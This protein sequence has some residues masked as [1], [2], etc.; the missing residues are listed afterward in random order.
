VLA[1]GAVAAWNYYENRSNGDAFS[2]EEMKK[3]NND[4]KDS[5]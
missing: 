2:S 1:I 5:K 4:K 3:W